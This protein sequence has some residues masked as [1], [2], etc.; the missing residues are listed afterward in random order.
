MKKINVFNNLSK[1]KEVF[2][3]LNNSFINI[4]TCGPTVYDHSHIGHARSAITWDVIVR[5][6]RFIGYKVTW[7]RNIT[8]ID[9][10]IINRAKE[11]NLHPDKVA[12]IYTHS[13]HEDMLALN[14]EWPDFEPRAT[15]YIRFD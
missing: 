5:F 11:T 9:D 10:K 6:F 3:P 1:H 12:R 15:Q 2:E 14:I 8:D 7:T 13:F 4:Y